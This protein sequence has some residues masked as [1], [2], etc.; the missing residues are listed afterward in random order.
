MRRG[1]EGCGG[2]GERRIVPV[3]QGPL[4]KAAGALARRKLREADRL[5]GDI[6]EFERV[7]LPAYARWEDEHLAPLREERARARARLLEL[8]EVLEEVTIE[9]IMSGRGGAEVLEEVQE[10]RRR[11]EAGRGDGA[12]GAADGG[13]PAGGG[14]GGGGGGADGGEDMDA[15]YP[16]IERAFRHYWRM[17]AG[18]DPDRLSRRAYN[19]QFREFRARFAEAGAGWAREEKGAV[20]GG[21]DDGARL[22]ELY[23]VLVRRLHPDTGKS[24]NDPRTRQLWHDLQRAYADGDLDQLEVLL[25]ITDLSGGGDAGR[26]TLFHLREVANAIDERIRAMRKKLRQM[27]KTDAWGF[28]HA[29][30]RDEACRRLLEDERF[31]LEEERGMVAML[32]AEC[33]KIRATR[34]VGR[35]RRGRGGGRQGMFDF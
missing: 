23:R 9:S 22:K 26:S 8:R 29:K 1:R 32:E 20:G 6:E 5:A 31:L 4:R 33:E 10:R 14:D 30:D 19:R 35:G 34:R 12:G 27:K 18:E 15:G 7:V 11:E 13:G 17:L 25:V 28:R 2:G 16:E 24:R 21:R 3:D